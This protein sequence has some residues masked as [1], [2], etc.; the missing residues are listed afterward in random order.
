MPP[1]DLA[2]P[3]ALTLNVVAWGCAHASTGWYVHRLPQRRLDHDG[4]LWRQRSWERG[5]QRYEGLGIRRWKDRLPEAGALFAGGMSKR[6][7][8]SIDTA[9]LDRFAVETRRAE[10]GHWLCAAAIPIF[11]IWNPPA[12]FA[13]MVLYGLGVNLPFIAVQRF[14]R[15]RIERIVQ[16]LAG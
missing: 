6:H 16:R 14:N 12:I 7:L 13:V 5:G 15:I 4:W 9:G 1:I 8:P 11:A 3:V 2:G 10:L